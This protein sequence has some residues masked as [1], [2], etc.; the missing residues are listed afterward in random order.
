MQS[1][2]SRS[3]IVVLVVAIPCYALAGDSG[4]VTPK[5]E[6]EEVMNAGIPFAQKMLEAHGEFYPFALARATSGKVVA[7]AAPAAEEHPTSQ[8]VIDQL[9]AS[10]KTGVARGEYRATA[11]FADARVLPPGKRES[12][13]AVRVSLEHIAGYCVDVFFPY[14]RGSDGKV[15]FGE[16]FASNRSG[17]VFSNCK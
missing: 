14:S 6:A 17:A 2:E 16:I 4:T 1:L 9:V 13:D 12:T 15:T 5:A 3:A 10:L 8:Q 11:I 7:V